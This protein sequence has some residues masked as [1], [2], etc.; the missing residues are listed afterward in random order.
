MA[1]YSDKASYASTKLI[2][3][4]IYVLLSAITYALYLVKS[5]TLIKNIGTIRFTCIS[6]IVS[7]LAV[8]LHFVVMYG[9]DILNFP[10]EV[11]L[12]GIAIAVISTVIPSFFM[13]KGISY[14]GSSN[15]SIIASIGPIATIFLSYYILNERFTILHLI[16]TFLVLIGIFLI[17][18]KG[19]LKNT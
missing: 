9:F 3:G 12:I 13:A 1:F 19:N 4:T 17:S 10:K 8:L 16:G 2:K 14:I 11:Y 18:W 5:D 7:C 6:M 15:M